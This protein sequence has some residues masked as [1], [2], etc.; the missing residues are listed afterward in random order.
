MPPIPAS[1]TA[2]AKNWTAGSDES[3]HRRRSIYIFA[4][5]NLRFPFLEV[6]DAPDSNIVCP[7]RGRS[8]TA[9][10]AL[11]LLNGTATTSAAAALAERITK[12]VPGAGPGTAQARIRHAFR[13]VLGRWPAEAELRDSA[14]F[15]A[16]G[17]P[18]SELCR[19]LLNLSAFVYV[20]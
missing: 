16:E 7:E 19:A 10:Q 14:A 11:S 20:D 2:V 4:R 9:P 17:S 12:E 8:T 1:I 5:R 15:L 3:E 18:L 13:L 6:F